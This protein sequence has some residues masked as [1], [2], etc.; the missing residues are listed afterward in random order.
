MHTKYTAKHNRTF[1]VL[2]DAPTIAAS[3]PREPGI[4]VV[5]SFKSAGS[6]QKKYCYKPKL[7]KSAFD[8]LKKN[9]RLY[10]GI[11]E[12]TELP[13]WGDDVT[14]DIEHTVLDNIEDE[15]LGITLIYDE[16]V[17]GYNNGLRN[18]CIVW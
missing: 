13:G 11:T 4:D 18:K 7:L 9:N 12:N 14:V 1:S 16:S 5:M 17:C 3:L 6:G 10:M 15:S 8:F 2:N